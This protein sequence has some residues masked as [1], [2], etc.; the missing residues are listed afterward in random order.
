M[1]L[2]RV[3]KA[4]TERQMKL[5]YRLIEHRQ[6]CQHNGTLTRNKPLLTVK[7]SRNLA[8]TVLKQKRGRGHNVFF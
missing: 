6:L 2:L 1:L 8:L 7:L 4:I 5:Q 3:L